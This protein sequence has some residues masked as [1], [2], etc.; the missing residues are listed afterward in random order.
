MP[1]GVNPTQC[2]GPWLRGRVALL[3]RTTRCRHFPASLEVVAVGTAAGAPAA[4]T[5]SA[6]DTRL[7]HAL[8]VEVL[9]R[10]LTGRAHPLAVVWVRP[11]HHDPGDGDFAWLAASR[12]AA[13][14]ALA[15]VPAV[16]VVSRWGWTELVTGA[17]RSWV[18]L[19][20]G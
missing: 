20:V 9:V 2:W 10:L 5:W 15:S 6:D 13:D 4:A 19:R 18:R 7:D 1:A 3:R 8:R 14:V 16:V 12:V 11:G 17:Q